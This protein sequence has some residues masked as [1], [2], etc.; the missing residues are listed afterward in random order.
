MRFLATFAFF[1]SCERLL[2]V[3]ISTCCPLPLIGSC[4]VLLSASVF[5]AVVVVGIFSADR[6]FV[7]VSV[8]R[9]HAAVV[10]PAFL[11]QCD[12]LCVVPFLADPGL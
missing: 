4:T 8:V 6:R 2:S 1:P 3:Q 7:A 11:L 10:W 5:T 12:L 9:V